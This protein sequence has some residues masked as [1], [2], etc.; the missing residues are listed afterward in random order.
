MLKNLLI[1]A[2]IQ[3]FV[4]AGALLSLKLPKNIWTNRLFALLIFTVSLF[5]VISS[6]VEYFSV[7]PKFF[8]TAYVLIYLYCPIYNLFV[9]STVHPQFNF[10][11]THFIHILPTAIYLLA[12][13]RWFI[14]TDD[15]VIL[16]LT[17][18]AHLELTLVDFV[19]IGLNIY[20]IWASWKLRR[21][22]TKL[23]TT[24][25]RNWA[26]IFLNTSLMIANLAWLLV[27]LRH[28]GLA[29]YL[30]VLQLSTVYTSMSLMIFAFGYFLV[31]NSGQFSVA[32]IMQNIKYKNVGLDEDKTKELERRIIWAFEETKPYRNPEFSLTELSELCQLDK[33]KISYVLN[34]SMKTNFAELLNRYR[35]EEFVTLVQSE[36]YSNFSMLGIAQEAGFSSKSTFY[37]AFKEIKGQTPKEYFKDALLV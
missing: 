19:S 21:D 17:Q 33:V 28:L 26:F 4:L 6:Q 20:F 18:G 14:M 11:R 25:S 22:S 36:G 3:G 13:V 2:G 24:Y 15:E 1:F 12:L 27:V 32:Q 5:L 31:V 34:T 10:N 37:K 23:T 8:L 9:Q 35:V 16:L 7:Y 29:A 30:P